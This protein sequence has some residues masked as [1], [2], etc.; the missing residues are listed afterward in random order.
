MNQNRVYIGEAAER[1][2]RRAHTLRV[3]IYDGRLPKELM[4]KRDERN[5]RY[6]TEEQVEGMKAWIK[7]IDLRPGKGLKTVGNKF[8]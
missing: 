6:W 3:W 4:P 2:G 7:E 8:K 5:W 1:L